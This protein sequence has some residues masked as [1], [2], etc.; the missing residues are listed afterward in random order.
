MFQNI[1]H[2][3]LAVISSLSPASIH[4]LLVDDRCLLPLGLKIMLDAFEFTLKLPLIIMDV[5]YVV[6]IDLPLPTVV[7][8]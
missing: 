2:S 3:L 4:Y 6:A 5:L 7:E 8:K 1:S